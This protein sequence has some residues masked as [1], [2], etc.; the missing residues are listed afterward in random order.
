[1]D[2]RDGRERPLECT[3]QVLHCMRPFLILGAVGDTH[4]EGVHTARF[5]FLFRS[6]DSLISTNNAIGQ[7]EMSFAK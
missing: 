2:I 6:C 3:L 5:S 7:S 4:K 1:M